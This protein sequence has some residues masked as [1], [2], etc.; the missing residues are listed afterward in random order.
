MGT[1]IK[2]VGGLGGKIVDRDDPD[3]GQFVRLEVVVEYNDD[4][5]LDPGAVLSIKS[6]GDT[7]ALGAHGVDDIT[8]EVVKDQTKMTG[9]ARRQEM[10]H[11]D[12]RPTGLRYLL[13]QV[14]RKHGRDHLVDLPDGWSIQIKFPK[15]SE[16]LARTAKE[17]VGRK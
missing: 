6:Q 5:E 1:K 2:H 3:F 13:N 15:A 17:A 14:V 8:F 7:R 12:V 9:T 4:G 10:Q 16:Q 11:A